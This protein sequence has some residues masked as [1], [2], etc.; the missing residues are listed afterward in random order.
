MSRLVLK[1]PEPVVSGERRDV[2]FDIP[3]QSA[4]AIA[5]TLQPLCLALKARLHARLTG[6]VTMTC[7]PHRIGHRGCVALRF[8]GEQGRIDVLITVSGRAQFP[9]AED[10]QAPRWYID[11]ADMVD[12]LYLVLWL[13]ELEFTS[14]MP[15]PFPVHSSGTSA[16][17]V[18]PVGNG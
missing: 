9:Q 17:S 13:G 5:V 14:P 7:H 3:P 6:D 16:E 18:V 11:V 12:A 1:Y 15:A 2:L 4:P 8:Q 10:Y